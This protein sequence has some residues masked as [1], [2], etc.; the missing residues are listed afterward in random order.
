MVFGV[1]EKGFECA[2]GETGGREVCDL[3]VG[4]HDLG[5]RD[6]KGVFFLC[7]EEGEAVE[8]NHAVC[9]A[10]FGEAGGDGF[11]GADDD[12]EFLLDEKGKCGAE[13]LDLPLWVVYMS[14]PLL[15][16]T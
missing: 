2:E 11:G 10:A 1:P 6:V 9:N 8:P 3:R 14:K 4:S 5:D 13:G 12:L 15:V 7:V 16:Q